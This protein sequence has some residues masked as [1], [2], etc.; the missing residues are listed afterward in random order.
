M[1]L[2]STITRVAK[3]APEFLLGTG[4][5]AVGQGMRAAGKGSSIWTKVKAGGKALE[6]DIAKKSIKGGFLKRTINSLLTTPKAVLTS[7]KAGIR[8]AKITGKNTVKGAL[9]GGFKAIAKR[10]PMI[11]AVL[12]LALETPNII[13]AFKEGGAGAGL[14]EIGG[15]GV[16]LGAM[17]A[18]AAIGSAICPGVGTIVGSIVGSIAGMFIRGNTYSDK[19]AEEETL[20]QQQT[21]EYTQDDIQKLQSYGLTPE[22]IAQIQANGYSVQDVETLLALEQQQNIAPQDNTKVTQPY[23]EQPVQ[24]TTSPELKYQE[25]FD[26]PYTGTNLYQMNPAKNPYTGSNLYQMG[27]FGNPYSNDYHYQELFGN[28]TGFSNP[29]MLPQ[30]NQYFKFQGQN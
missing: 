17:A 15:A 1:G 21:V 27:S 12:T 3:L 14:K 26:K 25:L 24:Q 5:E 7:G 6:K 28:G 13:K 2:V 4:A 9:T 23:V 19:K 8:A 10:M 22:E 20:K 18:G 29:Y 30:Q 11:G 16:E